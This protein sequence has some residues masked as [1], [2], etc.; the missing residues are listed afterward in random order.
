MYFRKEFF[1]VNFF[2]KKIFLV[3]LFRKFSFYE[4]ICF[5]NFSIL[6]YFFSKEIIFQN[7]NFFRKKMLIANFM[8][9]RRKRLEKKLIWIIF[10]WKKIQ[11]E[12]IW[13]LCT[14]WCLS[15]LLKKSQKTR[16]TKNSSTWKIPPF[17]GFLLINVIF[18]YSMDFI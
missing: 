11:T 15:T 3:T 18:T 7:C 8:R 6:N 10:L 4:K 17:S 2:R 5:W 16:K 12:F 9:F 14:F 13:L 1:S